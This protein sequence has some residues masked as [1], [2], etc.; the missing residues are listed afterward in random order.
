MLKTNM[1]S[2]LN[3]RIFWAG[4]FVMPVILLLSQAD[5]LAELYRKGEVRTWDFYIQFQLKGLAGGTM[6]FLA[7]ILCTLPYT[8][9]FEEDIRSGMIKSI[10]PRTTR[11][12]YLAGKVF[13]CG[14][15]GG[16]VLV[17]GI[18]LNL[19]L[20]LPVLSPM[21]RGMEQDTSI[22]PSLLQLFESALLFFTLGFLWAAFGMLMAALTGNRYV[23]YS[24]PFI[25]YYLLIILYERY[26]PYLFILYPKSWLAPGTEWFLGVFGV[27]F[28][29]AELAALVLILFVLAG[30]RRL[31]RV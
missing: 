15:S 9:S 7:P 2:I 27:L 5:G 8:A 13:A 4:C 11:F 25:C 18:L 22:W 10:L 31:E 14:L 28:W 20:C 21:L 24:A 6:V 16:L 19:L 29:L 23:A 30:G 26:F 12:R 3:S 1:R 17:I